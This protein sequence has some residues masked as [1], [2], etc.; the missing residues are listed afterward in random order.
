MTAGAAAP[1]AVAVAR[2]VALVAL[3]LALGVSPAH[4]A[5]PAADFRAA[6]RLYAD[7]DLAAAQAAYEAVA[8]ADPTGPW[9]DDALSEAAG[10]A[11]KRGELLAA[12]ALWRRLV[13]EHPTSRQVRRAR[14]RLGVIE[15]A[16]GPDGR[17][18]DVARRHD[19]LLAEAVR[20]SDPSPQAIALAQL[21]AE[22]PDYPRAHDARMWIADAWLRVGE[23]DRA[24]AGY[25]AAVPLAPDA[26]ARWRAGKAH[27]DALALAGRFDDAERV[28]RGLYGQ[29]DALADRAV[30]RALDDLATLRLRQRLVYLAW[31]LIAAALVTFVG[32]A[33]RSCGTWR[34]AARALTRPPLEV[35]YFAP[36]ALLLVA[37]SLTGNRL[38]ERAVETILLGG[39]VAAWGAGAGLEAARRHGRLTL[40]AAASHVAAA[41]AIV[42][43]V[44]YL[45]LLDD[46]LIDMIKETL[47]HGHD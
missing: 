32:W 2:A 42:L 38:V 8:A 16:I 44:V 31:A 28:Y 22:H 37:T 6:A 26:L 11:E 33:R 45:A 40:A 34:A 36:V 15:A 17:W 1:R 43:A 29:S 10:I 30:D 35:I 13:D 39:L 19:A 46:R 24:I 18:L 20:Q 14:A 3:A 5:D 27:G 4:A 25:A 21:I 41:G 9:A 12:R 7:G 23:I 47:T